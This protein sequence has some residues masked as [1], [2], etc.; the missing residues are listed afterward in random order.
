[1]FGAINV[2]VRTFLRLKFVNINK[3]GKRPEGI[4]ESSFV[5]TNQ[6]LL[7]H[8]KTTNLRLL[9]TGSELKKLIRTT[10]QARYT[11]KMYSSDG[12]MA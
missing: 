3:M 5:S 4:S 12:A 8:E 10:V 6:Q 11:G 2:A 9:K 7:K 1:M